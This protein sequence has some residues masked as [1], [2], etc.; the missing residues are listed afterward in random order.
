[1]HMAKV[2]YIPKVRRQMIRSVGSFLKC[3]FLGPTP[4]DCD[5]QDRW[6]LIISLKLQKISLFLI[7]N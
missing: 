3:R 5:L 4:T 2:V 7:S 6:E 1:M